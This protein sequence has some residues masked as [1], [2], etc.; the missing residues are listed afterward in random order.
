MRPCSVFLI[1]ASCAAVFT[2]NHASSAD[3][4]TTTTDRTTTF[5][6]ASTATAIVHRQHR[7]MNNKITVTTQNC[8]GI[9]LLSLYC[10]TLSFSRLTALTVSHQKHSVH[11]K[12]CIEYWMRILEKFRIDIFEQMGSYKPFL[13]T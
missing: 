1:A 7:L 8:N 10:T 11:L 5:A 13:P 3:P 4:T 12:A 9:L 2:S 6:T